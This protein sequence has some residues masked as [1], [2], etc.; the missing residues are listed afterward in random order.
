M[1]LSDH[2]ERSIVYQ[3]A[4]S[5]KLHSRALS[6]PEALERQRGTDFW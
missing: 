6:Q 4:Q 1:R 3:Q 5:L 2:E